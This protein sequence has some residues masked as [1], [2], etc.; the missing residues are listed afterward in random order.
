VPKGRLGHARSPPHLTTTPML[1]FER[2]ASPSCVGRATVVNGGI[3]CFAWLISRRRVMVIV[4][5]CCGG[6]THMS[7]RLRAS[8]AVLYLNVAARTSLGGARVRRLRGLC[9]RRKVERRD[10]AVRFAQPFGVE[11]VSSGMETERREFVAGRRAMG[12]P[13]ATPLLTSHPAFFEP[14]GTCARAWFRPSVRR[15]SEQSHP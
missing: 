9:S 2:K 7:R 6:L 14:A 1:P 15:R 3:I 5:T 4:T 8:Q 13:P 10:P 11:H 12:G